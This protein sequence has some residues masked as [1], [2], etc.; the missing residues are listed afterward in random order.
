M[1]PLSRATRFVL[2]LTC[3]PVSAGLV[4][5]GHEVHTRPRHPA[6]RVG[7]QPVYS[8]AVMSGKYRPLIEYLSAET[9]Y[10]VEQ[11][12]SLSQ[13]SYLS[14]LEGARADVAFLNPLLYLQVAKTKG[15]YPLVR[16]VNADGTDRYRGV[17]ITRAD[18][19]VM[20]VEDI[21]GCIAMTSYKKGVGG[22][23]GQYRLLREKGIDPTNDL[24]IVVG[25]TQDEVAQAVFDGRVKAGFVRE[26]FATSLGSGIDPSELRIIAY[27][28][29]FPT[30]TFVAFRDTHPA[31]A[32][33]VKGALLRLDP[34]DARHRSI[35]ETAGAAGFVEASD[36]D[37]DR[38]RSI[39]AESGLPY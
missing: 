10:R 22:Y 6:V 14:A 23:L 15:A 39:V 36:A 18:S 35:L 24:T 29:Y 32:E 21:R 5:C 34:Q 3:I 1:S 17:I 38:L 12:S 26:D 11:I 19:R 8:L 27:T 25:R 13:T 7:I 9:G 20:R 2:L 28:D 4:G 31:V 16:V 37:Y 30:W 33:A